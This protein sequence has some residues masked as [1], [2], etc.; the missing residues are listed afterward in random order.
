MTF[1]WW[2]STPDGNRYIYQRAQISK[3]L[4]LTFYTTNLVN[5]KSLFELA[6]NVLGLLY[7]T[8]RGCIYRY[9]CIFIPIYTLALY[10]SWEM[11][12]YVC[13]RLNTLSDC[14]TL[15]V[16]LDVQVQTHHQIK[17]FK[18]NKI[19]CHFATQ[20]EE[21]WN[22]YRHDCLCEWYV[23]LFHTKVTTIISAWIDRPGTL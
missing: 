21:S 14:S 12:R 13:I 20:K 2:F 22:Y 11:P 19:I 5:V 3:Y 1:S 8:P 16:K 23:P 4:L 9:S 18:W 7:I 17:V 10:I 15:W 6:Y